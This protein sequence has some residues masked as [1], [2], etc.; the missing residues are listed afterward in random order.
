MEVISNYHWRET[1]YQVPDW[2]GIE[3]KPED[4]RE[5]EGIVYRGEFIP[6]EDFIAFNTMWS[7]GYPKGLES[8]QAYRG[9]SYFSGIV[10][11]Y[12]PD[13]DWEHEGM[14]QVGLVLS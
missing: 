5:H 3:D 13:D 11:R 4:E 8:W 9:D 2:P 6:L 14:L 7:P 1:V 12:A 10:I